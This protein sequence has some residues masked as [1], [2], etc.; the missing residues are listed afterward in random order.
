MTAANLLIV[1][2][3]FVLESLLSVDNATA[4][5]AMV[6][7]L[8][9]H[10]RKRA[11]RYGLIGAYVFRGL[12]LLAAAWLVGF[13]WLKVAGGVYLVWLLYKHLRTESAGGE[14]QGYAGFWLTVVQVE[15]LD[16]SLSIDNVFAAV[17]LSNQF[18]VVMAGVG[19]GM[20]AMRF[21]AGW[22]VKILEKYPSLERSAFIVIGLLGLKLIASGLLDNVD[23]FIYCKQLMA[24]HTFDFAFSGS[25]M[26]IFFCPLIYARIRSAGQ[27]ELDF[28]SAVIVCL[29]LGAAFIWIIGAVCH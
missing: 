29:A 8:P 17:A 19:I 24:S 16:L 20:L 28:V 12:C 13:P 21:V 10:Q 14:K 27:N 15:I 3:L 18:W 2:N 5:A 26:L 22:F 1:F 23:G 6:R 9:D 7:H 11:L 4:L 25:M